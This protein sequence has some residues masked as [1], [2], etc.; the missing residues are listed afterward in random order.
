MS[1]WK[2]AN[3]V[4]IQSGDSLASIEPRHEAK[5]DMKHKN[6][7]YLYFTRTHPRINSNYMHQLHP[8]LSWNY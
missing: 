1:T 8:A 3:V 7:T 6:L 4:K 2:I 5:L